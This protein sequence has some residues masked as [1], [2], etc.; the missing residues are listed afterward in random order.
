MEC[1]GPKVMKCSPATG[2]LR[3]VDDG[4]RGIF[5]L[6]YCTHFELVRRICIRMLRN[7]SE[8][9]DLTRE[10]FLQVHRKM[11]TFRREEAF[12]SWLYRVTKNI[13]LVRLRA[14]RRD[15]L[16]LPQTEQ[17]HSTTMPELGAGDLHLSGLFDA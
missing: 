7:P 9:E 12:S 6:I 3:L 2:A 13:V 14:K 11:H 15:A 17:E 10:V 1:A 16:S 4:D 8:A 5:E